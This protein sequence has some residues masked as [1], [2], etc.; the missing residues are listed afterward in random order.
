MRPDVALFVIVHGMK[1]GTFT[2]LSLDDFTSTSA[3][4]FVGA[5]QIINGTDK[6]VEI[7][8]LATKQADNLA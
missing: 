2:G 3:F 1:H 8:G 5:R 7:A 4:D 6:D